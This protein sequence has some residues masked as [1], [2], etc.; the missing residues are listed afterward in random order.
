MSDAKRPPGAGAGVKVKNKAPAPIQITA[1]QLLREA[2]ERKDILFKPVRSIGEGVEG[3]EN[4][5]IK[6]KQLEE[7]VKRFPRHIGNWVKYA[8]W[9]ESVGEAARARS[10]FE[11]AIAV[12]ATN[13]AVWLRYAEFEI[14]AKNYMHARNVFLRAVTVLPRNEQLWY[15]FAYMEEMLGNVEGA[16]TVYTNWMAWEPP[17]ANFLSF[18]KFERR[19]RNWEGARSVFATLVAVHGGAKNW[20]RYAEFEAS[21][22]QLQRAE[23][24]FQRAIEATNDEDEDDEESENAAPKLYTAYARLLVKQRRIDEARC[25]LQKSAARFD[26]QRHSA[27]HDAYAAFERQHGDVAAIEGLVLAKRRDLYEERLRINRTNYDTWFDYARLECETGNVAAARSVFRRATENTPPTREKKFWRRFV[28]LFLY[29]ATWEEARWHD[30]AAAEAVFRAALHLL[31]AEAF[32]FGK[33]WIAYARFL[34]RTRGV[35]AARRVFGAAI[36]AHPKGNIWAAYIAMEASLRCFDRV[37][38]LHEAQIAWAPSDARSWIAY[39]RVE[40]ALGDENRMRAI[41]DAAVARSDIDAPECLWRAYID[42]ECAAGAWEKVRELYARLLQLSAH[43][44]V[45]ISYA[46]FEATAAPEDPQLARDVFRRA[47][48]SLKAQ[49]LTEER[50]LL[51]TAW[52]EFEAAR[53]DAQAEA[54]VTAMLPERV[55]R[56]DGSVDFV[57]PEDAAAAADGGVRAKLLQTAHRWKQGAASLP[58]HSSADS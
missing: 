4:R 40:A 39:A 24:V 50:I 52:R 56:A 15:K 45:W 3:D 27:L 30:A 28:W 19:Q 2:H 41:F 11:R 58:L 7:V 22:G 35:S 32:T 57:W 16:R 33:V 48:A 46:N 31:S 44:K 12:D 26:K 43:V 8:H 18:A 47:A 5:F 1:E 13:A 25:T 38:R 10:V 55:V 36:G 54:A 9:E 51:L 17:A 37:R 53:A 6:R 23:E 29:W 34:L 21:V 14:R 42:A 20:L 49:N